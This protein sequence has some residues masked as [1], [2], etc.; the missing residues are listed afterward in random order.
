MFKK[1]MRRQVLILAS[2]QALFQTIAV[3]VATVSSLAAVRIAPSPELATAPT[4]TMFLGTATATFPASIWMARVGRRVGFSTGTLLGTLGGIVAAGGI[5]FNSLALLCIGTFLVGSYQAFAQFYRF[6]ASEV[7]DEKF[8][9]RAISLVLSGGVIAALVG[10]TLA[11]FGSSL[12]NTQYV[13][14]FLI[15]SLI[16]LIA[17]LILQG[18]NLPAQMVT[19]AEKKQGRPLR[20]IIAQPS[21]RVAL[22]SAVTAYGIMVLAMTATPLAMSHHGH[23]LADSAMVIQFHVLGMFLPSFFTGY[24]I[25]RF[26]TLPIMFT[27]VLF[28]LAHILITLSGTGTV[29]F[30][31]ALVFLGVGWNFLYIGGTTLLTT[32]YTN[33]EKGRAQATNDMTIFIIGLICSLSA[34]ILLQAIGW[35]MLNL[36]LLPWVALA[37]FTLLW[38]GI[39]SRKVGQAKVQAEVW[40]NT[41][42]LEAKENSVKS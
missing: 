8:R 7:A 28:F 2:G 24:L 21:Y 34:G 4:A 23:E 31:G 20:Q 16:S 3:L 40:L 1:S 10:P 15:L 6:A 27:G 35:Q 25:S 13:G 32:S 41:K 37:A 19:P 26:G 12:F 5:W 29:S 14:S 17:F 9:P 42:E 30:S 39:K 11:R 33:A 18:L 38:F 36:V 22:F